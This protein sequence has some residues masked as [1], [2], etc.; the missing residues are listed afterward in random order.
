MRE[1]G[2]E[3]VM[4]QNHAADQSGER[5]AE[6]EHHRSLLGMGT[7]PCPVSVALNTDGNRKLGKRKEERFM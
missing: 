5:S 3:P 4:E 7:N 6:T 1:G 2:F